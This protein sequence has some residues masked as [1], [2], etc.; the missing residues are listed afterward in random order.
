MTEVRRVRAGDG[1][2][3][4]DVRLR[5]LR[6]DP[7]AFGSSYEREVSR[8]EEDWELRAVRAAEGRTQYLVVA[9]HD[10]SFI[11]M[12]GAYQ[13]E[14][15]DEARELYGMWVS[16]DNRERGIGTQLVDALKDWSIQNGASE[17]RL[18]VVQANTSA[19]KLYQN[20][21]FH[22]TGKAQPLPSN[23]SLIEVRMVCSL[24]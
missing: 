6:A 3:L 9:D 11:G 17:I 13:P 22:A 12:A 15:D 7:S 24:G 2:M 5:A 14:G 19:V 16:P 21:G 20:S 18:W 10:G 23:P 1:P 8:T 4:R